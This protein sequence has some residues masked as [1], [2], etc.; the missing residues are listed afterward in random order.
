V[1]FAYERKDT[2]NDISFQLKPGEITLLVAPNGSGKTTLLWLAAGLLCPSRGLVS[3]FGKDPFAQRAVLGRVG[4]VAEGAPL[5][6]AWTGRQVLEFQRGTFPRWNAGLSTELLDRF[7]LDPGRMVRTLS[8]GERGKLALVAVLSTCPEL[9]VLDEPTLGLDVASRRAI[10]AELLDRLAQ[11]GC[12]VLVSSHEIAEAERAADRLLLLSHGRLI[13]DHRVE[14][15]LESHRILHWEADAPPPALGL[16]PLPDRFSHRALAT[17]WDET[18]ARAWLS[19]GGRAEPADLETIYLG[20]TGEV[21][22]A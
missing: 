16:I 7:E 8:R 5:P 13:A 19:R 20:L 11:D 21:R 6:E 17:A 10:S 12:S 14:N 2:L 1:A 3:V 15:L 22:H 9:L 18:A 4:F